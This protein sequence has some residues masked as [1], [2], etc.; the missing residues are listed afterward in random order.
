MK[1]PDGPPADAA[2]RTDRLM[3]ALEELDPEGVV[4]AG[5]GEVYGY[6]PPNIHLHVT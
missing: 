1:G 4:G 3:R 6:A 2:E 5:A